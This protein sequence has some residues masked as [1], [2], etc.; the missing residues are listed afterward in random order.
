MPCDDWSS[1]TQ[2]NTNKKRASCNASGNQSKEERIEKKTQNAFNVYEENTRLARVHAHGSAPCRL[3]KPAALHQQPMTDA[4][5]PVVNLRNKRSRKTPRGSDRRTACPPPSP[6]VRARFRFRLLIERR[7]SSRRDAP[8][9]CMENRN[10][11]YAVVLVACSST[12]LSRGTTPF[13]F[14]V[15]TK[16]IQLSR[17][18]TSCAAVS[19]VEKLRGYQ[20]HT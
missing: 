12:P 5:R 8:P 13:N 10:V 7:S 11:E 3:Q 17:T 16:S 6:G 14:C 19:S 2:T 18:L 1:G 4:D 15:I 20:Q 9:S